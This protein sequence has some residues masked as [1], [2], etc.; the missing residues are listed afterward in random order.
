MKQE[1]HIYFILALLHKD[2]NFAKSQQA[3]AFEKKKY[4]SNKIEPFSDSFSPE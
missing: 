1:P 3:I 2:A 4:L